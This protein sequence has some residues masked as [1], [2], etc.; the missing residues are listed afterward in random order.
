MRQPTRDQLAI[1]NDIFPSTAE[2]ISLLVSRKTKK[3]QEPV[4]EDVAS[5]YLS[6][7]ELEFVTKCERRRE[8]LLSIGDREEQV[9]QLIKEYSWELLLRE[10]RS[11]V[12]K[13]LDSII[14]APRGYLTVKN[15]LRKKRVST[16]TPELPAGTSLGGNAPLD[17]G[18]GANS[19]LTGLQTVMPAQPLWEAYE[20][21]RRVGDPTHSSTSIDNLSSGGLLHPPNNSDGQWLPSPGPSDRTQARRPWTKEEGNPSSPHT[22]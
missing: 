10:L 17:Q 19:V 21:A 9:Q 16:R 22:F 8:H 20:R 5:Q 14:S 1:L 15:P 18:A 11:H 4:P 7:A 3:G 6:P 12:A 13:N 2:L